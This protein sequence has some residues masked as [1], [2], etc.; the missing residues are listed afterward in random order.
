MH[1]A[2]GCT[3]APPSPNEGVGRVPCSQTEYYIK[4]SRRYRLSAAIVMES[5]DKCVGLDANLLFD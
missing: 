3:G 4:V 2:F 1:A 5:L